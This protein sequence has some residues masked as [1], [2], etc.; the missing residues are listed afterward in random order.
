MVA[1]AHLRGDFTGSDDICDGGGRA[2]FAIFCGD[3]KLLLTP[4]S[5]GEK[6]PLHFTKQNRSAFE[7]LWG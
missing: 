6:L 1:V 5:S 3:W 2:A 7:K 4:P